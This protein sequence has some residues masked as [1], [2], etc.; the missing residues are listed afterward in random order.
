MVD[1]PLD[2][3]PLF[4]RDGADIPLKAI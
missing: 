2:I 1:A 4:L 3:I